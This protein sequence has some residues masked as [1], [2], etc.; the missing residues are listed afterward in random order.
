MISTGRDSAQKATIHGLSIV[1]GR[2]FASSY[3]V[4]SDSDKTNTLLDAYISLRRALPVVGFDDSGN[5]LHEGYR[6]A[7][8]VTQLGGYFSPERSIARKEW[9]AANAF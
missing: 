6:E 4:D 9:E 3:A 7:Y 2:L 5:S 1:V 8:P